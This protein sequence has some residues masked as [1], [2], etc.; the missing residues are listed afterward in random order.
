M[1]QP[2]RAPSDPATDP[3]NEPKTGPQTGPP[4]PRVTGAAQM[5]TSETEAKLRDYLRRV[6]TD[7]HE[8]RRR[9]SRLQARDTEPI[10]IIGIGCRYPGGVESPEDLWRLVADGT[11][12]ISGF[13]E[14]RGW[15]LDGLYHP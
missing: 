6:T 7:L 4:E 15:D 3:P 12:A 1:D 14:G 8:T 10:A 9:L 2:S 13:P 11:D 5:T